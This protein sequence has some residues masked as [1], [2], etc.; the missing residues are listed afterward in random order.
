LLCVEI[1]KISVLLLAVV[2][3]AVL[4]VDMGLLLLFFFLIVVRVALAVAAHTAH[5]WHS[6]HAW[7]AWHTSHAAHVEVVHVVFIP[8]FT[9]NG[10]GLIFFVFI[11][12]LSPVSLDMG[13]LDLFLSQARPVLSILV[14]LH[15]VHNDV[16]ALSVPLGVL[17]VDAVKECK[18]EAIGMSM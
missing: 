3:V 15:N 12:P 16:T 10:L 14:G 6:T 8:L 2:M 7:H 11:D 4:T 1:A 18:I 9:A 5:A 17:H 13:V